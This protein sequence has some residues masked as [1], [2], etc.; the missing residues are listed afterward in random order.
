MSAEL[1]RLVGPSARDAPRAQR[2]VAAFARF[3]RDRG[4]SLA[5]A[6]VQL[7]LEFALAVFHRSTGSAP[8]LDVLRHLDLERVARG[9]PSF[10]AS[11]LV[12]R[13][14]SHVRKARP[15]RPRLFGVVIYEPRALVQL[16]PAGS[17]FVS[18]RLRALVLL[19]AVTMLRPGEPA[20]I[21][22][23]SIRR[24]DWPEKSVLVFIFNSKSS[25]ASALCGDSNHVEFLSPTARARV[26]AR[27]LEPDDWCPATAL[28][29]WLACIRDWPVVAGHDALFVSPRGV[30]VVADTVG[31]WL[32]H[33]LHQSEVEQ[34]LGGHFVSHSLR[35][36]S[37]MFLSH[38]GVPAA[39]IRRRGGW[40][41]PSEN[42]ARDLHYAQFRPVASNFA[43]LL[44]S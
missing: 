20:S 4:A 38:L 36:A 17:S 2:S 9:A 28:I 14:R 11:P 18:L 19:R 41:D 3:A 40:S 30:P 37:N 6:P 22:R 44:F 15:S 33:F 42:R 23:A 12:A 7:V 31:G 43:D 32:N 21:S 39:E 8:A 1:R 29:K 35:S 26:A 13:F 5:A 16:L 34:Q 24:V 27:G 25:A 10:A